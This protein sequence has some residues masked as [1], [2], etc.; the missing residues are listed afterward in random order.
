MHTH[1]SIYIFYHF[2]KRNFHFDVQLQTY[3]H[4]F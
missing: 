4:Y 1:R 2:Q 3:E